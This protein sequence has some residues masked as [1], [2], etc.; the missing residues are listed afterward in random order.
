MRIILINPP[1]WNEYGTP[2]NF[3]QGTGLTYLAA[4]LR[5]NH[6]IKVIDADALQMTYPAL[7][8]LII[9]EKQKPD[10]VMVTATTLS[11]PSMIRTVQIS[12]KHGIRTII[13]GPHATALPERSL[14]ETG[15]DI[16]I[17]GEGEDVIENAVS[18][19]SNSTIITGTQPDLDRL[20]FPARDLAQPRIGTQ[21]YI[22]NE[23]RLISPEAV[24]TSMRGC[25]HRCIF[26]SHPVYRPKKTRRRNPASI[27]DEIELLKK[28]H[29]IRS[30][31]FYDD[32]WIGQ[33]HAQNNWIIDVC[34]EIINRGH[35]DILYKTQGRCSETFVTPEVL[36]AMW[37]ANFRFIMLGCES[38]SDEVLKQNKKDTTVADIVHTV[39][40][41]HQK[42][43]SVW[44]F[45]MVGM[46]YATVKDEQ[47]TQDLI[48]RLAPQIDHVPQVT[49][50]SP[51]PG[52]EMWDLY[53]KN[54]WL[55]TQDFSK[56]NQYNITFNNPWETADE[57]SAWRSTL[58]Q[59]W[60]RS[61]HV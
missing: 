38:G 28:E 36:D 60:Q 50:C 27:V 5:N 61:H 54:G 58:I 18:S 11:Y 1:M 44:T 24:I 35:N 13:G 41:L 49:I 25:P 47:M 45:W 59:T 20:P 48:S 56:Y 6:E 53:E 21:S 29:G 42:R 43:I 57:I 19:T 34:D 40:S 10:V 2:L 12:K 37:A 17:V 39:N 16:V 52:S 14:K 33:S 15:A 31:F 22:G 9:S 8:Q 3:N 7:E 23:P 51:L 4:V 46:P 26:C 32:E 30:I 55:T